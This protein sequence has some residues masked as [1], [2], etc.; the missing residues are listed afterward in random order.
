MGHLTVSLVSTFPSLNLALM[1]KPLDFSS[2]H[3][4]LALSSQ[5]LLQLYEGQGNNNRH[6][7]G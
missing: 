7:L 4:V 6:G 5:V 1:L 3:L 2:Q